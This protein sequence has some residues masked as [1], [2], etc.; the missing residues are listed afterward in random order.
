MNNPNPKPQNK[1]NSGRA[2]PEARI[3]STGNVSVTRPQGRYEDYSDAQL[4]EFAKIA[5]PQVSKLLNE[6]ALASLDDLLTDTGVWATASGSSSYSS[7]A[8]RDDFGRD[9]ASNGSRAHDGRERART[10]RTKKKGRGRGRPPGAKN[11][12]PEDRPIKIPGRGRGRPK[13]CAMLR[14]FALDAQGTCAR[15]GASTT[16]ARALG[17]V[18]RP[19][20]HA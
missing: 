12:R 1:E 11:K 13:V 7:D 8:F 3:N 5:S 9:D 6:Q 19:A 18:P 4:E 20:C 17:G 10:T 16:C 2:N 14:W 15:A